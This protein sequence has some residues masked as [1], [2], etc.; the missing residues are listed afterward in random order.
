MP[1]FRLIGI[2][3]VSIALALSGCAPKTSNAKAVSATLSGSSEVP[4]VV[5]SGRGTLD[6]TLNRRTNVLTW[7]LTYS[8]LNGPATA[9]RFHGPAM[10][11]SN[12]DVVVSM[13]GDLSSPIRGE[14]ALT[15]A[16]T[17]DLAAGEWYVNL[18]TEANVDGEI[19]GQIYVAP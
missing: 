14:A 19:R 3:L 7:L 6:A 18:P 13:T 15:P 16:Q 5:T 2:S 9:G 4:K 11:G 12:A 8:A 10:P 17:A 1:L